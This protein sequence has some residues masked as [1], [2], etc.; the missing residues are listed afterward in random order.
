M[1]RLFRDVCVAVEAMHTY[2]AQ[3]SAR[4]LYEPNQIITPEDQALLSQHEEASGTTISQ[5][6]QQGEM[7]PWAHRDIKPG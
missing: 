6:G 4:L 1:L 3:G 5:G 7:V 2:V